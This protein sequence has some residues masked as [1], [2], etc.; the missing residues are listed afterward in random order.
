[1]RINLYNS[2]VRAVRNEYKL[3]GA[4]EKLGF[5]AKE[6]I[7]IISHEVLS[8]MSQMG[9]SA[10]E[11]TYDVRDTPDHRFIT[12][13]N[14]LEKDDRYKGWPSQL[15]DLLKPT[16]PG[17]LPSTRRNAFNLVFVED[18]SRPESLARI[19]T[20]VQS[21]ISRLIPIRFGLISIVKDQKSEC[22]IVI[23]L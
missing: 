4:F 21:M 23:I 2:L 8:E 3:I 10:V 17:Q 1:M 20:E 9:S 15:A 7:N 22:K 16:Y 11:S 5:T 12:W 18:L 6:A 13:W 19:T 14:D